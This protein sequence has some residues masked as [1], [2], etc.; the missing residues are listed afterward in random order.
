MKNLTSYLF[1]CNVPLYCE[2]QE[3]IKY[4]VKG[5]G[6]KVRGYVADGTEPVTLSEYIV[7]DYRLS[8]IKRLSQ[9][10]Q[11]IIAGVKNG[12]E[13]G[14]L[15]LNEMIT[16]GCQHRLI[17]PCENTTYDFLRMNLQSESPSLQFEIIDFY[18][19]TGEELPK[20]F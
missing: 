9:K 19:C 5:E 12:Q 7:L 14:L 15:F 16:D 3:S 4:I 1:A 13:Q 20:R 11:S 10:R 6:L 18:T 8:G 2:I 17:M